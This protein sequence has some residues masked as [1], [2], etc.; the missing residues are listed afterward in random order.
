ML[1]QKHEALLAAV[2]ALTEN[3]EKFYG[4]KQVA[5]AS[6]KLRS[7]YQAVILAAKECRKEVVEL[8]ASRK[9]AKKA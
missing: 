4:E 8:K 1:N 7:G 9:D 6:I 5:S 3:A 2:A